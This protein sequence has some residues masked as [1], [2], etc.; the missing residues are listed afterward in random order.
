MF[1]DLPH[2]NIVQALDWILNIFT[3]KTRGMKLF[4]RSYGSTGVRLGHR[5]AKGEV[6]VKTSQIRALVHIYLDTAY[7]F[8]SGVVLKQINGIPI[9]GPKSPPLAIL[10]CAY[11]ENALLKITPSPIKILHF[12]KRYIDDIITLLLIP[13]NQIDSNVANQT[14]TMLTSVYPEQI[15]VEDVP[16]EGMFKFLGYNVEI[17]NNRLETSLHN[18]NITAFIGLGGAQSFP[19]FPHFLGPA[20]EMTKTSVLSTML[21]A[22]HTA[23]STEQDLL[24]S[25]RALFLEFKSLSYTPRFI[26]ST[27]IALVTRHITWMWRAVKTR[28]LQSI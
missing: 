6:T 7:F 21:H 8:I 1:V 10:S 27:F 26:R 9:G 24:D 3:N 20:A 17:R 25:V 14:W 18:K 5:I 19:R 22:A 12:T 11:N 4:V 15:Q 28:A 23:S 2:D 13:S 16:T